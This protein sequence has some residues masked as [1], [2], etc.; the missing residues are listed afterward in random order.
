MI[1]KEGKL[2]IAVPSKGRLRDRSIELLK[3]SGLDFRLSG[4]QLFAH[5][6]DTGVLIVLSN[7]SDIPTLVDQGV[8]DLGITGSDLVLEKR[9]QVTEHMKLGYGVC[10]LVLAAHTDSGIQSTSDLAGKVVGTKFCKLTR[11]YLEQQDVSDVKVVEIQGAV[12]VMVLLGLV[13]AIVDIVETGTTLREHDLVEIDTFQKAQAVLIGT[14][15]PRDVELRDKLIRRLEGVLIA[16]KYSVLE[17]NCPADKISTAV[18]ITPGFS[19]PTVQ[20]TDSDQWLAVKVM[21]EK[22]AV[23]SIMDKLEEIGCRAIMETKL[24]NCRL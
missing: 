5:C 3:Q 13:D 17:Y 2:R 24:N 18:R 15:E 4:R 9:V 23:P 7:A 20:N 6:S 21:V 22:K 19:S 10:R 1:I 12:E 8:V 11:Q 16:R 14:R